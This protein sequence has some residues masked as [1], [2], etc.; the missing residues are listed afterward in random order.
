M[1]DKR[2]QDVQTTLG[3]GGTKA[4]GMKPGAGSSSTPTLAAAAAGQTG[5]YLRAL[6]LL[7]SLAVAH[8]GIF[9]RLVVVAVVLVESKT[10]LVTSTR[11]LVA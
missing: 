4:A 10:K 7:G 8:Y 5:V 9:N 1:L 6:S 3:A 11:T 2:L